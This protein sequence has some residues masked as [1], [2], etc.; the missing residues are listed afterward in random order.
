MNVYLLCIIGVVIVSALC[1][2]LLIPAIV[3]YCKDHQIY[4]IPNERKVHKTS[5]PRLGGTVF[6]PSMFISF[7]IALIYLSQTSPLITI[8]LWTFNFFIG[9]LLIYSMGVIDDIFGLRA[10]VKLIVQ[11]IAASILPAS[12]LYINNLYG[13]FGI[14]ELPY[15]VGFI[16]TVF[17]I[18]FVTNAI[19][20]IDGIDG[21]AGSLSMLALV[22]FLYLFSAKEIWAYAI[23]IAGLIGVLIP[24]LYF[25]ISGGRA[26][27]LK[28]FMG[29]SGSLTLGYIL[30]FLCV[31]YTMDN[32]IT[33]PH[34]NLP[35]LL[36]FTLLMV[37]MFDVVR[38]ALIRI[39]HH[40]SPFR[41]DK[42]HIHHRLLVLGL[43]QR[44]TLIVII[45]M[46]LAYI[47]I[48][49]LLFLFLSSTWV[50]F[51]DVVVYVL[52]SLFLSRK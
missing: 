48:N 21:L 10:N 40:T 30:G 44:H 37:P 38:V 51:I 29:D 28:I 1:G 36:P 4:D 46:A 7:L 42:N 50:F 25:N 34:A 17:L 22:G 2:F 27:G 20:L 18:V 33:M 41:A 26:N 39:A 15:I 6:L 43:S 32:P 12:G 9:L 13:F 23:F 35:F 31:K 49:C 47:L 19:N 8:N 24:F 11:I 14:Y 52:L 16:L 3:R 5:V 45:L